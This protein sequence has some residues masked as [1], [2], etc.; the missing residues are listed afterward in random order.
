MTPSVT[1]PNF[2]AYRSFWPQKEVVAE[3]AGRGVDVVCV[4]PANTLNSLGIPYSSFPPN[5]RHLSVYDWD[6][7]D[8]QFDELIQANPQASFICMID[9]NSPAWMTRFCH[10]TES[11]GVNLDDS[12]TKLGKVA[13]SDV[14]RKYTADYLRAFIQHVS[15]K[16]GSRIKGYILACG[17]TDEWQDLSRGEE[18]PART[19][20]WKKWLKQNDYKHILDDEIPSRRQRES[21]AHGLLRDPILDATA[22]AYWDFNRWLISDTILYFAAQAQTVLQHKTPLGIFFGYV[23]EH[24]HRLVSGG[25]LGFDTVFASPDLD[26]FVS[27]SSYLDREMGGA[28]GFMSPVDSV[29]LHNKGFIRELDHFTHTANGNPLKKWDIPWGHSWN[30]RWPDEASSI[31]GLRREFSLSLISGVSLWWFD[32]WNHWYETEDT[33]GAIGSM[34]KIW[35]AQQPLEKP[36]SVS[37][38]AVLVDADSCLY[39]NE[40]S[41][42]IPDVLY[43]LRPELGRIG[44]PYSLFS[45]ADIDKIDFTPFKL[46]IFPNLFLNR[47]ELKEKLRQKVMKDGRTLLWINLAGVISDGRYDTANVEQLTGIPFTA[48]IVETKDFGAW[49]S[50]LHADLKPNARFLRETATNAGVHIYGEAEEPI[51]VNSRLLASHSATGGLRTFRLSKKAK[52]VR[53]LFSNRIV[54]TDC[55]EFE[56][57]LEAP[58]TVL[59]QIEY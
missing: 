58:G 27:P 42:S 12:F 45:T 44:A 52:L 25:H 2:M 53:E 51:Y 17:A 49:K 24:K 4:F 16:Y 30:H 54:A 38:I 41:P 20:A 35:D 39:L 36:S 50:V 48:G 14:W 32:M 43:A 15:G 56:D 8:R 55:L 33:L 57:R 9:L 10:Y 13:A 31:A 37:E 40:S 11:S 21:C 34:K 46:V 22:I 59:Y 47:P 23:L 29:L 7:V 5:W 28:S 18:S 1:P 26:F 19:E 6:I 3:F